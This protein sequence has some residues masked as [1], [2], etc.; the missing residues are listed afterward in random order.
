MDRQTIRDHLLSEAYACPC[1][2]AP[3]DVRLAHRRYMRAIE[4][5]KRRLDAAALEASQQRWAFYGR[6]GYL[7][8]NRMGN[9]PDA[10]T[11]TRKH[12][13]RATGAARVPGAA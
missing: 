7:P 11:T 4:A 8:A 1:C 9:H 3:I 2:G 10:T 6:V 13:F 5:T 12:A